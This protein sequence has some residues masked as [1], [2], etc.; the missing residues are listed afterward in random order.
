MYLIFMA[1]RPKCLARHV[2]A[3]RKEVTVPEGQVVNEK[4][5]MNKQFAHDL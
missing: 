2:Y 5:I 4:F 3:G 1:Y